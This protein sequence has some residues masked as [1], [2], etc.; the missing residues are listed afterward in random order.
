M[1]LCIAYASSYQLLYFVF[2]FR[3]WSDLS[4]TVLFISISISNTWTIYLRPSWSRMNILLDAPCWTLPIPSFSR[5]S[6]TRNKSFSRSQRPWLL[7]HLGNGVSTRSPGQDVRTVGSGESRFALPEAYRSVCKLIRRFHS[8]MK[9]RPVQVVP[10]G[11]NAVNG[12]SDA[13]G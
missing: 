9:K 8:A 12:R 2:P 13:I 1:R 7:I 10:G 6:R 4:F 5:Q 11:E 3:S